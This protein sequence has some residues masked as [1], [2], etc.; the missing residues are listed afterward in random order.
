MAKKKM[1]IRYKSRKRERNKFDPTM[2][3]EDTFKSGFR[4]FLG[5]VVF[6]GLMYAGVYG[7]EKLG[8]FQAGYSAPSTDDSIDYEYIN[9]GTVFNRSDT[10]YLVMFDD[11]S[12]NISYDLY[13]DTL[14]GESKTPVYKVDMSK[15][16][17]S[18]YASEVGNKKATRSDELKI[19][20]KTLIKISNGKIKDY[21][22]GSD[23]IEAYLK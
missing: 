20:G 18:K 19:N 1:N 12:S 2:S 13:I 16:E 6:L 22:E 14:L 10:T 4:V 23:N 11:Y 9:V 7:M 21:I 3:K 17:N 15:K 5:V 8:V